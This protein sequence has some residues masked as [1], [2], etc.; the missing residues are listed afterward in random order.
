MQEKTLSTELA[1]FVVSTE[2]DDLPPEVVHKTK[3]FFLNHLGCVLGGREDA[4]GDVVVNVVS[5]LGGAE[6]STIIGYGLKTSCTNAALANAIIG[7]ALE[8]NDDHKVANM[9]PV[10]ATAPAAIAIGERDHL[11]GKKLIVA[12]ALSTE[13]MVR[14]GQSFMGLLHEQGFH[15][16]GSC[17]VFGATAA[18][19]KLLGFTVDHL[20]N[21]FGIAASSASGLAR[22]ATRT[23]AWTKRYHG[24]HAAMC[25]V[26]SALLAQEGFT[27]PAPVLEGFDEGKYGFVRS[28]SYNDQYDLSTI[29]TNLGKKWEMLDT[30]VKYHACCSY[31]APVIDCTL[32]I[33]KKYD[34]K[35]DD[36]EAATAKVCSFFLNTLGAPKE[37]KYRPQTVVHAQFSIPYGIGVAVNR[38][39]AFPADF[40]LEAIKD[41]ETLAVASRVK[42]ELDPEAEKVYPTNY[43]ATVDIKTRDGKVYSSH[44]DYPKGNMQNPVTDEELEEKF[45]RLAG[46]ALTDEKASQVIGMVWKLDELKDIGQL[47]DLIHK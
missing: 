44:T 8:Q 9:H 31:L 42:M 10:V 16:T 3:R 17:G 38:R 11:D 39:S 47:I 45:R 41:P 35:P 5:Q 23:G 28:F 15:T 37:T 18:V 13:I 43:V 33:I 40:T 12:E 4:V 14:L 22:M 19:G 20:V 24:G 26:L 34:L 29:N 7:Y 46:K 1:E 21:A 32:D 2:F 6:Q 30:A 36:V 25:G 27:G